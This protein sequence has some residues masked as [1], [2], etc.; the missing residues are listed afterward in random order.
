MKIN[1]IL[2][3]DEQNNLD[4]LGLLLKK[5]CP[6]VQVIGNALH[7]DDGLDLIASTQPDLLFLDIEMPGKNGFD[8]LKELPDRTLEVI[9][10]TAHDQYGIQAVKFS[11]IDYLL[12]PINTDELIKAVNKVT[13]KIKNKKRNEQLE[14]LLEL[15]DK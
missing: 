1:A 10:V 6:E 15:I 9:L 13:D 2:I 3:D 5:Y 4:H 7:V 12:K 8:L 14:N 11:T